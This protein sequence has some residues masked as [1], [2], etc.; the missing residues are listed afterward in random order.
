MVTEVFSHET[1]QDPT[2]VQV[3]EAERT[4][5]AV[6]ALDGDMKAYIADQNESEGSRKAHGTGVHDPIRATSVDQNPR[7]EL[8]EGRETTTQQIEIKEPEDFLPDQLD[9]NK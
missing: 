8:A 2:I 5:N 6:N 9:T 3:G 1:L 4:R 7:G